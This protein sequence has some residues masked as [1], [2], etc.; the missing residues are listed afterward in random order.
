VPLQ[1]LDETALV[2]ILKDP[3]NALTKQYSKLFEL[4]DV[5][6]TFEE[7]ALKA[8]AKRAIE[9]GTG[10]RGLR[11]ILE[12]MLLDTMFDLPGRDDVTEVRVTEACVTSGAPPLLELSAKRQKKE[13]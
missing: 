4:E 5:K 6:I 10:A 2:Q 3:K 7:S 8:I 11:A 12:E 13:A 9:R 1:A